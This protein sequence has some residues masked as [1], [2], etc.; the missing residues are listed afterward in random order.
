MSSLDY[1]KFEDETNFNRWWY[2]DANYD[3]PYNYYFCIKDIPPTLDSSGYSEDCPFCMIP[4]EWTKNKHKC[5]NVWA[6]HP[7]AN[8]LFIQGKYSG[9]NI[10]ND[11]LM[12]NYIWLMF[13]KMKAMK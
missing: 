13:Q 4:Q 6:Y 1:Y 8:I 5:G 7:K 12:K 9:L 3:N 2:F 11:F 10:D